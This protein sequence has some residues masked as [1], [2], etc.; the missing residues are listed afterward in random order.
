MKFYIYLDKTT[1]QTIAI[2]GKQ[3]PKP[4]DRMKIVY[5]WYIPDEAYRM[6]IFPEIPNNVLFSDRFIFI[7]TLPVKLDNGV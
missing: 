3:R 4:K 7:G 1:G 2:K 6:A 5:E